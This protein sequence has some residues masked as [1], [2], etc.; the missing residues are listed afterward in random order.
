MSRATESSEPCNGEKR[1]REQRCDPSLIVEAIADPTARR[2]YKA[3]ELP[4]TARELSEE[5]DVSESTVY[6]KLSRL[7]EAGLLRELEQGPNVDGPTRYVRR[8]DRVSVTSGDEVRID[9][10][11]KGADVFCRPDL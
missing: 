7:E 6:R 4:T 8:I 5:L 9:C 3:V 11:K 10:R 1:P 2:L